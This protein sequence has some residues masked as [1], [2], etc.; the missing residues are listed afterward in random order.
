MRPVDADALKKESEYSR[1][2]HELVVPVSVIDWAATLEDLN[3]IKYVAVP[4][5]KLCGSMNA[6]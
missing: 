1:E 2:R 6:L 4:Q 3:K 5:K